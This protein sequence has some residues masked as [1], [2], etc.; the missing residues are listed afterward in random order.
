MK[1]SA[2][3]LCEIFNVDRRTITKWLSSDPPVPSTLKNKVREFDCPAVMKWHS[4]RAARKAIVDADRAI[5]SNVS[6]IRLR[7]EE[8]Q[9][10]LM[11]LEL[12]VREGKMVTLE[13]HSVAVV[14]VCNRLRAALINI[15][16]NYAL[17]LE[18]A[19]L[20]AADAEQVLLEIADSITAALRGTAD[21]MEADDRNS[22]AD[23]TDFTMRTGAEKCV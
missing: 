1:M 14:E 18:R 11:E 3:D 10:R 9:A 23:T 21:E 17:P 4:E 13:A 22:Q 8:A 5:P 6:A 19:G 16:S 2:L 15:P 7:Y 12:A 20:S